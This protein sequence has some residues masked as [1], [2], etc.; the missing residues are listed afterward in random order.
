MT[1]IWS[2]RGTI[3]WI[4]IGRNSLRQAR[5][6]GPTVPGERSADAVTSSLRYVGRTPV[7]P[8]NRWRPPMPVLRVQPRCAPLLTGAQMSRWLPTR[9]ADSLMNDCTVQP[10]MWR[11]PVRAGR[12]SGVLIPSA[13]AAATITSSQES[14][15]SSRPARLA[16]TGSPSNCPDQTSPRWPPRSRRSSVMVPQFA[17]VLAIDMSP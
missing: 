17:N 6:R 3:G 5:R 8:P 2:R 4:S 11:W 12:Y 13:R 16:T 1:P 7:Q 15:G 10:S 9:A 14:A